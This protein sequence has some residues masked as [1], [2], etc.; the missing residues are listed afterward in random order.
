MK[1]FRN[2]ELLLY[3]FVFL[4]DKACI[5]IPFSKGIS[6]LYNTKKN[7][8][9]NYKLLIDELFSKKNYKCKSSKICNEEISKLSEYCFIER[10]FYKLIKSFYTGENFDYLKN[11]Y[12]K[13]DSSIVLVK[14]IQIKLIAKEDKSDYIISNLNNL[15]IYIYPIMTYT[16]LEDIVKRQ[17]NVKKHYF[18]DKARN[19]YINNKYSDILEKFYFIVDY[20]K[21]L[22][23]NFYMYSKIPIKKQMFSYI[24]LSVNNFFNSLKSDV[25]NKI[26]VT[27]APLKL[28]SENDYNT[29]INNCKY[30]NTKKD[31]NYLIIKIVSSINCRVVRS[32]LAFFNENTYLKPYSLYKIVKSKS[33]CNS[34]HIEIKCLKDDINIIEKNKKDLLIGFNDFKASN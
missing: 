29:I 32:K 9:M 31:N 2:I 7:L 17:F 25:K 23:N 24:K 8:C 28:T 10:N 3:L 34:L 6:P 12:L 22:N 33:L 1:L 4:I 16:D 15:A 11:N 18:I 14:D 5:S 19:I 21:I 30:S 20:L 26:I 13:V 27:N